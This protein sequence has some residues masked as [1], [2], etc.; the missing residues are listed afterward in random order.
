MK[1]LI[2]SLFTAAILTAAGSSLIGTGNVPTVFADE[3]A[4]TPVPTASTTPEPTAEPTTEP[5][6][7]P[8]P[9]P[10]PITSIIMEVGNPLMKVNDVP[11]AITDDNTT[12]EKI[13]GRILVPIR[14]FEAIGANV[15]WNQNEQ[16][17]TLIYNN[18]EIE[19]IADSTLAKVNK[20]IITLDVAPQVLNDRTK[21]PIRFIAETFGFDV[22]WEQ[23][24]DTQIET[25]TITPEYDT[26]DNTT[27]YSAYWPGKDPQ[28]IDYFSLSY[29]GTYYYYLNDKSMAYKSKNPFG[30]ANDST[31]D[32]KFKKGNGDQIEGDI[33][34]MRVFKG[35]LVGIINEK[36]ADGGQ[37]FISDTDG[38]NFKYFAERT[39]GARDYSNN[40]ITRNEKG[41]NYIYLLDSTN[42]KTYLRKFKLNLGILTEV[43]GRVFDKHLYAC[44]ITDDYVMYIDYPDFNLHCIR[45]S[46]GKDIA[47]ALEHPVYRL[48][49]DHEN[50]YTFEKID[51]NTNSE[52]DGET[53]Y[54][55][56]RITKANLDAAFKDA[57][58]KQTNEV[59]IQVDTAAET[60]SVKRLTVTKDE[61]DE[62]HV[63]YFDN[64]EYQEIIFND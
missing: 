48:N 4:K 43:E 28:H 33:D 59:V 52:T 21:M 42:D 15:D 47:L 12:P 20:N 40:I 35:Y 5:T 22:A 29:D 19:L 56:C 16:K 13:D 2:V 17:A 10:T 25:I 11:Q 23:N 7:T 62:T 31:K 54:I 53:K 64:T 9:S 44:S 38:N 60:E 49:N 57:D 61:N 14:A 37:A 34:N 39:G 1:K 24:K 51:T 26:F 41:I 45:R 32:I 50:F 30:N 55:P 46:D 58:E 18:T 36:N 27:N 3:Q 6:Q 63:F 8:E